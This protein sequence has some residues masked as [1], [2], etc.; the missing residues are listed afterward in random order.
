MNDSYGDNLV[1]FI[2]LAQW[3]VKEID[4]KGVWLVYISP[5]QLTKANRKQLL[6]FKIVKIYPPPVAFSLRSFKSDRL[7]DGDYLN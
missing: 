7:L 1:I 6:T 2:T 3:D 4:C 5:L